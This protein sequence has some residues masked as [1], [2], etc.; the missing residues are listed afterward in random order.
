MNSLGSTGVAD[1]DELEH[2][3]VVVRHGQWIKYIGLIIMSY[4]RVGSSSDSLHANRGNDH[5]GT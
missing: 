3:I 4:I 1:D 5:L 2:E